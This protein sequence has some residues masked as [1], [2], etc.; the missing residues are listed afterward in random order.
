MAKQWQYEKLHDISHKCNDWKVNDFSYIFSHLYLYIHMYSLFLNSSHLKESVRVVHSSA[1][2]TQDGYEN[3]SVNVKLHASAMLDISK[4][5]LNTICM[6]FVNF[7]QR[8]NIWCTASVVVIQLVHLKQQIIFNEI[9]AIWTFISLKYYKVIQFKEQK[10]HSYSNWIKDIK[11]YEKLNDFEGIFYWLWVS[12]NDL[13]AFVFS[14]KYYGCSCWYLFG[15]L[16]KVH[17][18][19][20]F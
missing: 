16:F 2:S 17:T 10:K 15:N 19:V 9:R 3:W 13:K 6:N 1:S 11:F 4:C 18:W 20:H 14:L 5:K 8:S 12:F 7:F